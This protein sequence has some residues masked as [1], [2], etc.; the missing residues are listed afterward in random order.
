M[1]TVKDGVME[2]EFYHYYPDGKLR[3]KGTNRN[4]R[5]YG[6][7]TLYWKN[8]NIKQKFF[9]NRDKSGYN[10]EYYENGKLR[11]MLHYNA[12]AQLDGKSFT[13]YPNGRVRDEMNYRNGEREGLFITKDKSGFLVKIFEYRDN[14]LQAPARKHDLSDH[15]RFSATNTMYYH[16]RNKNCADFIYR[17]H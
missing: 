3:E 16:F 9:I 8:G 1:I 17:I 12:K 15:E 13:F 5:Y 4:G 6:Y 14:A 10:Y 11:E 7:H 2:G